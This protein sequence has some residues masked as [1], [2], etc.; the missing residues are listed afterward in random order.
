MEL[1][2]TEVPA[3]VTAHRLQSLN[4]AAQVTLRR[5]QEQPGLTPETLLDLQRY[6]EELR[7]IE[8]ANAAI[9]ERVGHPER[10]AHKSFESLAYE[11]NDL[12][13]ALKAC[14]HAVQQKKASVER[15]ERSG[16]TPDQVASA[17]RELYQLTQDLESRRRDLAALES[18]ERYQ[19]LKARVAEAE[20]TTQAYYDAPSAELEQLLEQSIA[21][22]RTLAN[23]HERTIRSEPLA[24]QGV[25]VARVE[26]SEFRQARD[27]H[28]KAS[29]ILI[30]F[31]GL[32]VI[33]GVVLL[34]CFFTQPPIDTSGPVLA[35]LLGTR[36]AILL[37]LAWT[38]KFLGHLQSAHSQQGIIYHD[39]L[40]GL[41]AADAII[42]YGEREAK[43]AVLKEMTQ[44]YLS[45]NVNAFKPP[46][47]ARHSH[48]SEV[49]RL[50]K[51]LAPLVEALRANSKS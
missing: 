33:A 21:L 6:A 43:E 19:S 9:V 11:H 37:V 16:A 18:S 22:N 7:A 45:P 28:R 26:A 36:V 2:S 48:P 17:Q 24:V 5:M 15:S 49:R 32:T 35:S 34:L 40:A 38:I 47:P 10:E 42:K 29:L 8:R 3:Y 23:L 39:R 31:L 12:T 50:L 1:V 13:N 27:Y 25:H 44:A 20:L 4:A 51:T 46:L 14:E 30:L 41:D